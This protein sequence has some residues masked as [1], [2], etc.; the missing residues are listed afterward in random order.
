MTLNK[1]WFNND[2]DPIAL[3]DPIIAADLNGNSVDCRGFA[4]IILVAH[5]GLSGDTLS[6]SVL[7]DVELEDSPDD[8]TF[9]DCA[10]ADLENPDTGGAGAVTGTTTGTMARIDDPAEDN[11]V[12]AVRYVGPERFVRAV[13][14]ITGTHTVGMPCSV[15][16][17]RAL[18]TYPPTG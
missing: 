13:F 1:N 17:F 14:N 6:G 16:A 12:Y 11:L 10:D 5:I 2:I 18:P 9:T 15:M 7:L 8:S 4:S 3:L